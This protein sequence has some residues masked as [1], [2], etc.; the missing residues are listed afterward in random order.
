MDV[1]DYTIGIFKT[2]DGSYIDT[3]LFKVGGRWRT[4]SRSCSISLASGCTLGG[5]YG[6]LALV[7]NE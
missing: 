2:Q 4:G 7:F 6:W 1:G 3:E 5:F